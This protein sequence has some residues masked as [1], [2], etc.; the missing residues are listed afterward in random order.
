MR[1][2]SHKKI[3]ATENIHNYDVK[4]LILNTLFSLWYN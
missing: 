4:Y 3:I 2:F 1:F